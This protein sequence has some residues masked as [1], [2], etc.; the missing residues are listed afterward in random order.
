MTLSQQFDGPVAGLL[1]LFGVLFTVIFLVY[2]KKK[3]ER[4]PM[5]KEQVANKVEVEDL[6]PFTHGSVL[7]SF[8]SQPQVWDNF[9]E[10][11]DHEQTKQP[12]PH[13][14]G[15]FVHE[16]EQPRPQAERRRPQPPRTT[17]TA[18][19]QRVGDTHIIHGHHTV[20]DDSSLLTGIAVGMLLSDNNPPYLQ[21]T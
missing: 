18:H 2:R 7:N 11:I 21:R 10:E 17:S 16:V 12:P 15:N 4:V 5:P 9:R 1:I 6:S 14:K 20:H 8:V 13:V 19:S 3:S